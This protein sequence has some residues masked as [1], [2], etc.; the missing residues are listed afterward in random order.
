M[1]QEEIWKP[2][3]GGRYEVS[4]LGRVRSIS[5]E[6]VPAGT[7]RG[8][9]NMRGRVLRLQKHSQGYLAARVYP[10]TG[11][12]QLRLVHQ[13]VLRAFHGPPPPDIPGR[14]ESRHLDGVKT[15]NRADNLVWGS[16]KDNYRDSVRHGT[17]RGRGSTNPQSKLTESQVIEI[18]ERVKSGEVQMRLAEEYDVHFATINAIHKRKNWK[19]L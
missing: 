15:N 17:A 7:K 8:Y 16:T 12:R 14:V 10:T 1:N 9:R 13:L 11:D 19:H 4:S 2:I 18:R 3:F 6:I 5:R